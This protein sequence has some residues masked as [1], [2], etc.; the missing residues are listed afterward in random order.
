[1]P[2]PVFDFSHNRAGTDAA[3][4]APAHLPAGFCSIE[5]GEAQPEAKLYKARRRVAMHNTRSTRR[6][7]AE[8]ANNLFQFEA[9][10]EGEKFVGVILA[11]DGIDLTP[12]Q[13]N[14]LSLG[15]S[16]S[17]GYGQAK[18]TFAKPVTSWVEYE[19]ALQQPDDFVVITLLSDALIRDPNGVYVADI[20][21]AL[22]PAGLSAGQLQPDRSIFKTKLMGGFNRKWNLPLPQTWAVQMGSIFVYSAQGINRAELA[23][24][25]ESGIG[26]RRAEGFGRIA[27][28]WHRYTEVTGCKVRVNRIPEKS[29]DS[30]PPYPS[31]TPHGQ[32]LAQRIVTYQLRGEL[33]VALLRT[34]ANLKIS[35]EPSR[36]QLSRVRLAAAGLWK[37]KLYQIKVNW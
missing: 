31:L 35:G 11:D 4:T 5:K 29:D 28:D 19:P 6:V 17:A 12:L 36:S 27:V 33:D 20:S 7:M 21:A 15:K 14:Q 18:L 10:A 13:Q 8:G 30:P 1:M 32:K 26:E 25:V 9:L 16:R 3:L 34:I 37:R 22:A 24:L 2:L 23:R